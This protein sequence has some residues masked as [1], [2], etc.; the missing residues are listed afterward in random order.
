MCYAVPG[1]NLRRSANCGTTNS[2]SSH[3]DRVFYVGITSRPKTYPGTDP[4]AGQTGVP[5]AEAV[6]G[7]A[8]ECSRGESAA[9][10]L[11]RQQLRASDDRH[12]WLRRPTSTFGAVAPQPEGDTA[13]Q[14]CLR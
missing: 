12:G 2:L 1:A 11:P 14:M 5:S 9:A 3:T 10:S 6:P 7:T 8:G 4:I 13:A